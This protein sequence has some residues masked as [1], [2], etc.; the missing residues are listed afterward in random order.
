[1][2][3][4]ANFE[5]LVLFFFQVSLNF[6]PILVDFL[7]VR[8][9]QFLGLIHC[10]AVSSS[11]TS[12]ALARLCLGSTINTKMATLPVEATAL[13]S[14]L[15][16]ALP[17]LTLN[18]CWENV[19]ANVVNLVG[20]SSVGDCRTHAEVAKNAAIALGFTVKVFGGTGYDTSTAAVVDRT[21]A[22]S[23][24][25]TT[26][27]YF[28]KARPDSFFPLLSLPTLELYFDLLDLPNHLI[29]IMNIIKSSKP[30]FPTGTGYFKI[31]FMNG[32]NAIA[33]TSSSKP[34]SAPPDR[35]FVYCE[36][37]Q[38][39]QRSDVVFCA[40]VTLAGK[41]TVAIELTLP[42][43]GQ[44]VAVAVHV[45]PSWSA[46]VQG[47]LELD[48]NTRQWHAID[49]SGNALPT[50]ITT[51]PS[52]KIA[53]ELIVPELPIEFSLVLLQKGIIAGNLP[54]LQDVQQWFTE[55]TSD[56]D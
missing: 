36:Q 2:V 52:S 19:H 16:D 35:L 51:T 14:Q 29:G 26:Q 12:V 24:A 28:W 45:A 47:V 25:K 46:P 33:S 37:P 54:P 40:R 31:L 38:L 41:R 27:E 15:K 22:L 43:A 17:K 11:Y 42:P 53:R 8:Q 1:M 18:S 7:A 32:A 50:G 13:H 5:T 23:F 21:F 4:Q 20:G 6:H 34:G 30:L 3:R 10:C 44:P 39:P 48:M 55:W 56:N 9:T 49:S